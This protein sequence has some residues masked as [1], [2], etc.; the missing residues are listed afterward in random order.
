MAEGD[1]V[2]TG[3][4]E[5][6]TTVFPQ[7]ELAH[8]PP[9]RVDVRCVDG[10]IDAIGPRLS[11]APGD[12]VVSGAASMLPGLHD[13]HLHL[14]AMAARSGSV[15]LGGGQKPVDVRSALRYAAASRPGGAW[16]RAVGYDQMSSGELDRWRLDDMVPDRPVRVQHRSGHLWILNSLACAAVGLD[17]GSV[18]GIE[19]DGRG[20]ATGR[21]FDR[22]GWLASRVDGPGDLPLDAVGQRLCSWGVT[23]VTDATPATEVSHFDRLASARSGGLHQRVA[24]TGGVELAGVAAPDGLDLGPVKIVVSDYRPPSIES[25][26]AD[27]RTAHRSGRVAALHCVT[28]LTA[29]L[30]IAAWDQAGAVPGDRMEHGGVLPP[31]SVDRL[32]DL[33]ITVVTQPGF[34]EARGDRYLHDVEPRDLPFLYRCASLLGAGIPVA[35]STDAPFGPEDPWRAMRTAVDRRTRG[36]QVIGDGER[37]GPRGA[38]DLFLSRLDD[39]GGTPRVVRVGEPADL[40]LLDC[41]MAQALEDLDSAHVVATV[42]A[43]RIVFRRR[44]R[45]VP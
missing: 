30:A 6:L 37:L 41:S 17:D 40:C 31:D 32:A 35:G 18:E 14:M 13:H 26:A 9:G 22:D 43:G 4:P 2:P 12:E 44:D 21:L 3:G 34:I 27:L 20:V 8:G 38:L 15:D 5:R 29:V 36:G 23:G 10:R 19:R 39:P 16:L 45:P 28:R 7:V 11:R 33:G 24:V 42:V 25:L 1:R